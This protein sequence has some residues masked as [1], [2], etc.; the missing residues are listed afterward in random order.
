MVPMQDIVAGKHI[1]N[2]L[3]WD[4]LGVRQRI[5]PFRARPN[6]ISPKVA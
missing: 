6:E 3:E 4:N 5:L 1:S 2:K